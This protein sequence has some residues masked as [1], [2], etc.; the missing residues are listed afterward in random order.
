MASIPM[1]SISIRKYLKGGQTYKAF[2]D[3]YPIVRHS[4]ENVAEKLGVTG[5]VN[6]QAK[7]VPNEESQALHRLL[8]NLSPETL[9]NPC[10]MEE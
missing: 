6:I 1:S 2:I 3:D 9:V 5:A 4:A 7:Y 8:Q 10:K